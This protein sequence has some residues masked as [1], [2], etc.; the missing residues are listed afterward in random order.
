FQLSFAVV[1]AIVLFADPF[2]VFAALGGRRSVPAAQLAAWSASL[3][4][5]WIRMALP[6]S[7]CVAGSLDWVAPI[8][9]V[10]FSSRHADLIVRKPRRC[11]HRLFRSCYCTSFASF[12]AAA[13]VACRHF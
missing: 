9:P 5:R 1:G 12:N 4:P 11:S 3:D 10:V 13:V 7:I 2:F 8:D 6:R